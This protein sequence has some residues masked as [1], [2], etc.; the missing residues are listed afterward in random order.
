MDD[1]MVENVFSFDGSSICSDR[2]TV[3]YEIGNYL[4]S[5]AAGTVYECEDVSQKEHHALKI[6]NPLG[7][8]ILSP[9]LLRRCTVIMKGMAASDAVERGKESLKME[10]IWWVVNGGTKQYVA[11]YYSERMNG[12]KELSLPQCIQLWGKNPRSVGDSE[13]GEMDDTIELQT[14]HGTKL[15]IPSVPPKFAD[16]V[17]TRRRIFREISNMKRISNHPNV[18]RLEKVLELVQESKCES[19]P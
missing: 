2:N 16:F 15:E 5:G 8:K 10:H 3:I 6:L 12:I 1:D 14:S 18:I 7:Y 13:N 11:A 9:S 19:L 4:G 17:R